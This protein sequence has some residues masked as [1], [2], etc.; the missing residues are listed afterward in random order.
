M[1]LPKERSSHSQKIFTYG[2]LCRGAFFLLVAGGTLLLGGI[3]LYFQQ[4]DPLHYHL[5]PNHPNVYWQNFLSN[6]S[7]TSSLWVGQFPPMIGAYPYDHTGTVIKKFSYPFHIE[8][9]TIQ[10]LHT[11][12]A[13]DDSVMLWTST[14]GEHWTLRYNEKQ[15]YMVTEYSE[16]LDFRETPTRQLYIKYSLYAGD[17]NRAEDDNMGATIREFHLT[18]VP[19]NPYFTVIW[20]GIRFGLFPAVLLGLG[21]LGLLSLSLHQKEKLGLLILFLFAFSMRV[22]FVLEIEQVPLYGDPLDYHGKALTLISLLTQNHVDSEQHV[23]R[24][25]VSSVSEKGPIYPSLLATMYLIYGEENFQAVRIMQAF[26]DAISCLLLYSIAKRTFSSRIGWLAAI[27]SAGYLSFIVAT[28]LVMQETLTICV[29]CITILLCIQLSA[30]TKMRDAL[31]TGCALGV[32]ILT[33]YAFNLLFP[34]FIIGIAIVLF[35]QKSGKRRGGTLLISFGAGLV[36][37]VGFWMLFLWI[38]IGTPALSTSMRHYRG[39]YKNLY[40]Q[41]Q[42]VDHIHVAQGSILETI[43]AHNKRQYPSFEDLREAWRKTLFTSPVQAGTVMLKNLFT[44]WKYPYND[45]RQTL[46]GSLQWHQFYHQIVVIF[47]IWG[48]FLSFQHWQRTLFFILPIAYL[49]LICMVASIEIRQGLLALP[50][51]IIFAS[52]S[53]QEFFQAIGA[54]LQKIFNKP[55]FLL[56]AAPGLSLLFFA[57]MLYTG[58]AE[59]FAWLT[60]AISPGNVYKMKVLTVIFFWLSCIFPVFLFQCLKIRS[61]NNSPRW[62]YGLSGVSSVVPVVIIVATFVAHANISDEWREWRIR[63]FNSNMILRQQIVFPAE[64]PD[65]AEVYLKID[66]Q[67]GTGHYYDLDIRVNGQIAKRFEHGVHPDEALKVYAATGA[68]PKLTFFLDAWKQQLR[69]IQQWYTIPLDAKAVFNHEQKMIDVQVQALNLPEGS[70]DSHHYV[71]VFGDYHNSEDQIIPLPAMG[72]GSTGTSP[73]KFFL[74]GDYRLRILDE[75]EGF[76]QSSNSFSREV[77]GDFI[78]FHRL[79]DI[80]RITSQFFDGMSWKTKDLSNFSGT[81]SGVYR[82]RLVLKDTGGH[83]WIL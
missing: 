15:R 67:G 60:S 50:F 23:F 43:L 56:L 25:A 71:D 29:L 52:Y 81:Q 3:I 9:I 54:L 49:T 80:P 64:L 75:F 28:G 34:L 30:T 5:T 21:L 65:I 4:Y 46:V 16:T 19:Q 70:F 79:S 61:Q 7:G 74:D 51:L 73:F 55:N 17:I 18:A 83:Y 69:D 31:L 42:A 1:N 66:M 62:V 27:L 59:G 53:L 22:F 41:G 72:F 63:L 32:T 33:R 40:A 39:F 38:T 10:A 20:N 6:R 37:T 57:L 26:I 8:R 2:R 45:F 77:L 78:H 47:G 76:N 58:S 36:C 82:I 14:D 44:Y 12:W 68:Y 11:Q 48:I 24:Q 13:N 35:I